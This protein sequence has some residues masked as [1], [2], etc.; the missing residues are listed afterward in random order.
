MPSGLVYFQIWALVGC[1]LMSA[2]PFSSRSSHSGERPPTQR[3]THTHSHTQTH[4]SHTISLTH[5]RQKKLGFES[6]SSASTC[7]GL[8]TS[9]WKYKL[10]ICAEHSGVWQSVLLNRPL[11]CLYSRSS[12]LVQV[13][14]LHGSRCSHFLPQCVCFTVPPLPS[15]NRLRGF[16]RL[17]QH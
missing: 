14:S 3:R 13:N 6:R 5:R 15:V 10:M 4:T 1:Q 9:G 12:I 11:S 2:R 7:W 16:K 8:T 17:L